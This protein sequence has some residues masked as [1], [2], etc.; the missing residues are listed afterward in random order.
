MNEKVL[1]ELVGLDLEKEQAALA[2]IIRTAGSTPR[3]V[4][5]QMLVFPDGRTVG[6]IGGGCGEA[7]VKRAALMSLDSGKHCIHRVSLDST[8][9]ADEGMVCGGN[10]DV[11]IET[12]RDLAPF[13][14]IADYWQ[15]KETIVSLTI[16]GSNKEE[17]IGQRFFF[18]LE[19]K[20]NWPGP[21]LPAQVEEQARRGLS[22]L[23]DLHWPE[24]GGEV[25]VFVH[26]LLPVANLLILG[27]GYV[28]QALARL[29]G[30]LDFKITVVDDRAEFAN[31]HSLPTA[32]EIICDSF[33]RALSRYPLTANTYVVIVTRGHRS[34]GECLK[35]VIDSPA[36]YVGMIG[37][38]RK[39]KALFEN[40]AE[41]GVSRELL[42]TVHSPIGLDIGA[43]TPAEIAVSILA[44]IIQVR[45]GH[46]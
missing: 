10:M 41:Q 34:D 29:A 19:G 26:P 4:G 32:D 7:E 3:N 5:A 12:I 21:L 30:E 9:A 31:R 1:Q 22:R 39:V 37:S 38:R 16:V 43:E 44:E 42:K 24:G 20:G 36:A 23:V 17:I 28:G 13:Q 35:L 40:L 11:F 14:R 2:T 33:S 6:T 46:N 15:K 27:A 45:R 8:V 25:K 18:D